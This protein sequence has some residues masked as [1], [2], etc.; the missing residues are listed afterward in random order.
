M[1]EPASF[2][3]VADWKKRPSWMCVECFDRNHAL[4][5]HYF[6]GGRPVQVCP[7]CKRKLHK[8]K[9]LPEPLFKW[10]QFY[11]EYIRGGTQGAEVIR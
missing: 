7:K 4:D 8:P 9:R 11:A 1:S 10:N 2:G 3:P 6:M 5:T